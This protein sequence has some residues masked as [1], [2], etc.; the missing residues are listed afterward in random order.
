MPKRLFSGIDY[1]DAQ[2]SN[3][4][5]R[6]LLSKESQAWLKK[7]GYRNV[8]WDNVIRLYQK[9]ND[10]ADNQTDDST[11]EE[12]F[13]RADR[14]GEK[15]QS[16]EEIAQFNQQLSE[17]VHKIDSLLDKQFPEEEAEFVDF[18]GRR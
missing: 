9:I 13:L 14:I 10:L 5:R 16:S 11:L 1:R 8:G 12:L 15:Y 2:R 18:G 4:D 17:E 6:Q 7:N 3:R